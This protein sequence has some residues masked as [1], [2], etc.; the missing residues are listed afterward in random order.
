MADAG[1]DPRPPV[2][3]KFGEGQPMIEELHPFALAETLVD[4][5]GELAGPHAV[6]PEPDQGAGGEQEPVIRA[7][8]AFI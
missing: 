8:A 7:G 4:S 2:Q 3:T 6:E 1:A 5:G